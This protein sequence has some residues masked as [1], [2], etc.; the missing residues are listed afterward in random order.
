MKMFS[1]IDFLDDHP[2]DKVNV[3]G[4]IDEMSSY[5]IEYEDIFI[6]IGNSA[7]RYQ[8]IQKAENIG[9]NIVT[10]ISPYSYI[11][12]SAIIEK[13]SVVFPHA[14]V[15]SNAVLKE[16][17]ILSSNALTDHDAVI[18]KCCHINAGAIIPSMCHVKEFTKVDYG[19][20]Y[21]MHEEENNWEEKYKQDF[22]QE[23]S[24][25]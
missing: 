16:G 13:G 1:K 10:L 11:S 2:S 3:I 22:G 5:Y 21:K 19:Q 9:Y 25:F 24:F 6:A 18:G 7:L 12:R 14:V 17:C 23:P 4:K 20:V 15:Q 8:L